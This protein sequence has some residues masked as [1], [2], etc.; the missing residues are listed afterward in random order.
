V[1]SVATSVD[2]LLVVL[3]GGVH[4]LWGVAVG[5]TLLTGLAAE[6]GR[7]FDYWRG[8]LGVLVMVIMVLAPSGLLGLVSGGLRRKGHSGGGV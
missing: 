6:L 1:A 3:L 5:S 2:A 4:Q 7:G 8:A